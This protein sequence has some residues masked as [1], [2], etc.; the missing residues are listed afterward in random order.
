[1]KPLFILLA[2]SG[3]TIFCFGQNIKVGNYEVTD[4]QAIHKSPDFTHLFWDRNHD[5]QGNF[6]SASRPMFFYWDDD[7][8][9]IGFLIDTRNMH[10]LKSKFYSLDVT[11]NA[12]V[13]GKVGIGMQPTSSILSIQGIDDFNTHEVV[14]HGKSALINL[15]PNESGPHGLI[16]GDYNANEGLQ[17]VY[18]STPNALIVERANDGGDGE[19]LFSIDYDT[20]EAYFK[21]NVGIGV[22]NPSEKLEVNGTIRTKEVKVEASSWPDYVFAEGYDLMT[23]GEISEYIAENQHLPGLPSAEEVAIEGV[24][25]GEMNATLLEK[26]E[27]LTLHQIEQHKEINYLKAENERLKSLEKRLS[28]LESLLQK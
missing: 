23:L 27:E 20:K 25:L 28:D 8:S 3:S 4:I 14:I 21:Y 18:R 13:D 24:A 19:D 6:S 17:L 26:I 12:V 2:L 1:M 15:G 7:D 11:N 22:L 5:G 10:Y 16:F 9:A